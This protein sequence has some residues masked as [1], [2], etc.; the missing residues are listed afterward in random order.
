MPFILTENDWILCI[1][2]VQVVLSINSASLQKTRF[3]FNIM[4]LLTERVKTEEMG[5]SFWG[6]KFTLEVADRLVKF[7]E[8]ASTQPLVK[9]HV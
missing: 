3:F 8:I 4:R 9:K 1:K 7:I 6:S 2:H 5:I